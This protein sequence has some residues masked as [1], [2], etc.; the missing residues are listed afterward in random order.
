MATVQVAEARKAVLTP[1]EVAAEYSISV[2]TLRAHRY[3]KTGPKYLKAPGR[4]GHTRYRRA[5]I[6][7][8]LN[9]QVID[10]EAQR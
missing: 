10:P 4:S 2:H 7:A 1:Q 3:Y 8:W 6:E 9:G 5:D